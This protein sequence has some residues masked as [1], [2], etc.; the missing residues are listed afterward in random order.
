MA[1]STA[2]V[3]VPPPESSALAPAAQRAQ[4]Y[5]RASQAENTRRAYA[6]DW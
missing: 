4:E 3:L 1:A 6:S 5:F 2:L